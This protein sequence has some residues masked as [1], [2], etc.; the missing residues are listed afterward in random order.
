MLMPKLLSTGGVATAAAVALASVL[1]ACTP[2]SPLHPPG[3]GWRCPAVIESAQRVGWPDG[4][5]PWADRIA[6]RESRCRPDAWSRTGDAGAMQINHRWIGWGL[7]RAG[8]A[9]RV[10]DLFDLD[11]NMRAAAHV[12]AVQGPWAWTTN[13]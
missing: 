5:L 2:A 1:S 6:W 12:H 13:G 9:C 11:T 7:C 10:E 4:L 3:L 8:I